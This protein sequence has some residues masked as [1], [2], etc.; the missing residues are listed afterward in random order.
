M[1]SNYYTYVILDPQQPGNYQCPLCSFLF[2]PI[3]VGKGSNGRVNFINKSSMKKPYAGI[4]LQNKIEQLK[5]AGFNIPYVILDQL[6][7]DAAYAAE[8]LLTNFFGLLS[9]G[10][11]LFNM[12]HGGGSGWTLSESTK[13]KLSE[14]NR[15]EKNPNFGTTWSESRREK[16]RATWY[17]KDRSRPPE[18]MQKTWAGSRKKYKLVSPDGDIYETDNLTLFCKLHEL[19]LSSIRIALT[20]GN[21]VKP[22]EHA[23]S[24]RYSRAHGW[25][26][27]YVAGS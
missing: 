10:G 24:V 27:E 14:L 3:Y 23:K 13:S 7:E 20:N 25:K 26:V 1:T 15:G 17:S 2:K 19:P 12:K 8:R 4:L 11:I 21:I 9:N 22:N 18:V 16:W 6:D 5:T